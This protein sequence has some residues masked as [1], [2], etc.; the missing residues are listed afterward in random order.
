MDT[1][2]SRKTYASDS[3]KPHSNWSFASGMRLLLRRTG[4]RF[5]LG[6]RTLASTFWKHGPLYRTQEKEKKDAEDLAQ[7]FS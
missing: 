2:K 7:K 5:I 3:E 4:T 6:R 1:T